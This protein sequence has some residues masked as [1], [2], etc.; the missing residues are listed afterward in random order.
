[1]YVQGLVLQPADTGM[2][3]KRKKGGKNHTHREQA[4]REKQAHIESWRSTLLCR[5]RLCNDVIVVGWKSRNQLPVGEVVEVEAMKSWKSLALLSVHW[6]G[7][8]L[9]L[10]TLRP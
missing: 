3:E 5:I 6:N 7:I 9:S 2:T 4:Q 1:M 10:R 8:L